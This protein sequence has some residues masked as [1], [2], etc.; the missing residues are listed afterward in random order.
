MDV[1][2]FCVQCGVR[3]QRA[4]SLPS[5]RDRVA[6]ADVTRWSTMGFGKALASSLQE[7]GISPGLD[8]SFSPLKRH[9][10]M[11]QT[12]YRLIYRRSNV[13]K[14]RQLFVSV[15]FHTLVLSISRSTVCK[16]ILHAIS[17]STV[18]VS[19]SSSNNGSNKNNTARNVA[20]VTFPLLLPP[21]LGAQLLLIAGRLAVSVGR[22]SEAIGHVKDVVQIVTVNVTSQRSVGRRTVRHV[23]LF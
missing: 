16:V 3:L 7:E 4:N 23:I 11:H 18:S 10:S 1:C 6:G 22:Y 8:K 9:P 17:S 14:H 15:P 13:P 5:S 19:S 20:P 12:P 2:W 21:G